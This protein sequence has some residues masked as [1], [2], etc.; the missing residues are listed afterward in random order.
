MLPKMYFKMKKD[1]LSART[2]GCQKFLRSY[3]HI[4]SI[5]VVSHDCYINLAAIETELYDIRRA[6]PKLSQ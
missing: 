3:A 4:V 1:E 6:L 5:K 2:P